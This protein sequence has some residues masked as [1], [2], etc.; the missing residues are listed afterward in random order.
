[1]G[2]KDAPET[3]IKPII[4][5]EVEFL[6]AFICVR[7]SV[8]NISDQPI[9]DTALELKKDEN[10]LHFIRG[11]YPEKEGR[12]KLGA[13]E[14]GNSRTITIYFEPQICEDTDINCRMSFKDPLGISGS[15]QMET[16]KIKV[17]CPIFNKGQEISIGRLK[18]LTK[19]LQF[20]DSL[21]YIFLGGME[22]QDLMTLFRDVIQLQD[23]KHIKTFKTSDERTYESWNYGKTSASDLL[24]KCAIRRV[25]KSIEIMASGNDPGEITGLLAHIRHDLARKFEKRKV[26]PVHNY[27]IRDYVIQ[28][29][30]LLG[31]CDPDGNCSGDLVI[32]NCLVQKSNIDSQI[33]RKREMGEKEESKEKEKLK[34]TGQPKKKPDDRELLEKGQKEHPGK[35]IEEEERG[36]K[37]EQEKLHREEEVKMQEK[38]E[39]EHKPGHKEQQEKEQD[40]RIEI[41]R[42]QSKQRINVKTTIIIKTGELSNPGYQEEYGVNF[43]GI[44]VDKLVG[45]LT[46]NCKNIYLVD[47]IR[48][49][50]GELLYLAGDVAGKKAYYL[51]TAVIREYEGLTQV[52][53]R[54]NSDKNYGINSF[55]NDI[56]GNLRHDKSTGSG[57]VGIISKE[58]VTL[59]I[60]SVIRSVEEE[61]ARRIREEQERL[62][63]EEVKKKEKEK[64]RLRLK[65]QEEKEQG[66]KQEQKEAKR[67]ENEKQVQEPE[68]EADLSSYENKGRLLRIMFLGMVLVIVSL[69]SGYWVYA[70]FASD[71]DQSLSPTQ[72]LSSS[73]TNSNSMEL[74]LIPAG[75]FDMGSPVNDANRETNEGPVHHVKIP[76]AFY[77]GKYEVT[78]KQWRK[79][80]GNNPSE[81]KGDDLPVEQVSWDDVQVFIKKLNE[82]EHVNKYRLPAEAQWEYAARAESSMTFS[83]SNNGSK[84][85]D[86]AW[87]MGN[88][89][90]TTHKV[91]LKKPNQ[92]GLYDMSGN[93]YE[94]VQDSYYD[95]YKIA[96]K[97]GSVGEYV[98]TSRVFR[99]GSWI[100][101]AAS[102]RLANREDKDQGYRASNL[103]FRL[104]RDL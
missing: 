87:Y 19:E 32:E 54:A 85:G 66:R 71:P 34:R 75:E 99:G 28:R 43:E 61:R 100:S 60:D 73:F 65:E 16:L 3:P 5:G 13:I 79:V 52:L 48:I 45:V 103:G 41:I 95:S 40:D 14:P 12:I 46:H 57:E 39:H 102:C 62:R 9:L 101:N 90:G 23:V 25:T 91:G 44:G 77:M 104:V 22:L 24:V 7:I 35:N 38:E 67:R 63:E 93:V 15:A 31:L 98:S 80:M 53:L 78:Q 69:A 83:F 68:T 6:G 96:P 58:Q 42:E 82:N 56:L 27:H 59:I 20:K 74:V 64:N 8:K 37:K 84:L 94:W 51:L 55:L 4:L 1:M 30:D 2:N 36:E 49:D 81:F 17:V 72:T 70:N 86:Y 50:N 29:S 47:E 76:N 11:E 26:Q 10:R 33:S 21:V 18:E 97:D 92:F 89:E 88:S